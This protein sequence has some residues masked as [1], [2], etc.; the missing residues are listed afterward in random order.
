MNKLEEFLLWYFSVNSLEEAVIDS[1]F[2]RLKNTR[3]SE[4]H[5]FDYEKS[6]IIIDKVKPYLPTN[7]PCVYIQILYQSDYK[8]PKGVTR[9]ISSNKYLRRAVNVDIGIYWAW[10]RDK[11]LESVLV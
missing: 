7:E 2:N 8:Y 1:E 6:N 3:F 9:P 4:E 10:V 11:K 5:G